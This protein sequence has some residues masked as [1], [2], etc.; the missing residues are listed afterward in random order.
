MTKQDYI[1]HKLLDRTINVKAS[2]KVHRAVYDRLTEVL[3]QLKRLNN[4]N[5]IDDELLENIKLIT[6]FIEGLY[7]KNDTKKAQRYCWAF[8]W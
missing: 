6:N 1:T 5:E 4:G 3:E 2:C 7:Q 8:V